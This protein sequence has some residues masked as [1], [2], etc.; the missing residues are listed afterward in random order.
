VTA[1]AD[2]S[3]AT[4]RPSCAGAATRAAPAGVASS[5]GVSFRTVSGA[6]GSGAD[7]WGDPLGAVFP[8]ADSDRATSAATPW[9]ASADPG[10][11]GAAWWACVFGASADAPLGA[12]SAT[13]F[14]ADPFGAFLGTPTR[15]GDT[16]LLGAGAR[17][18][19]GAATALRGSAA[20]LAVGSAGAAAAA[21]GRGSAA[22][23]AA[24]GASR[25]GGAA[26]GG[27]ATEPL[28]AGAPLGRGGG[29]A[30]SGTS[31]AERAAER[32]RTYQVTAPTSSASRNQRRR[33]RGGLSFAMARG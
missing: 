31:P 9:A 3:G 4:V 2:A 33:R 18:A 13:T 14:D 5:R 30:N 29:G 32:E 22:G 17:R 12:G 6:T 23:G 10:A 1:C 28:D 16:R 24:A 8:G 27:A 15:S 25:A 26:A 20:R 21:L 19:V 7:T 11:P